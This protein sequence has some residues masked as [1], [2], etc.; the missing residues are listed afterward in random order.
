MVNDLT[1]ELTRYENKGREEDE[2]RLSN[3]F[4]WSKALKDVEVFG[5]NGTCRLDCSSYGHATNAF[6]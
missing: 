1:W 4:Q 2:N 5:G 6:D 3:L